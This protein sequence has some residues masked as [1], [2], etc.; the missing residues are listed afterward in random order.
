MKYVAEMG[1]G[2]MI[3]IP[4]F[5][6]TGSSIQKLVGRIHKH[7]SL[8]LFFQK[9]ESRLIIIIIIIIIIIR[10]TITNIIIQFNSFI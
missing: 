1:S 8:L 5:I 10:L 3:Y 9:K 7:V 6:K 2:P 4:S